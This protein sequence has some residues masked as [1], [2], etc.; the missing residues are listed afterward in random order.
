MNALVQMRLP[1]E[2]KEKKEQALRN[3]QDVPRRLVHQEFIMK[4]YAT[5]V[6]DMAVMSDMVRDN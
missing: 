3:T 2:Y 1:C 4:I 6:Q 5:D